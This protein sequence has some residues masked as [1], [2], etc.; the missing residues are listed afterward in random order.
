MADWI[1]FKRSFSKEQED[2]IWQYIIDHSKVQPNGYLGIQ[3]YVKDLDDFWRRVYARAR[4]DF[5]R[6]DKLEKE[7]K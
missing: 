5:A 6:Y 1:T 7:H 4:G 2:G 3:F